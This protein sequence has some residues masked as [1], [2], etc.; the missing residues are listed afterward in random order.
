MVGAMTVSPNPG[1]ILEFEKIHKIYIKGKRMCKISNIDSGAL[2]NG[3]LFVLI[4][5]DAPLC[6]TINFTSR[7]EFSD[8][9]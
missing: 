8:T 4:C 5:G 7:L 6:G 3:N 2:T 1:A 9:K